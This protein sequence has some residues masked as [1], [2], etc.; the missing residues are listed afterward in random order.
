VQHQQRPELAKQVL[1]RAIILAPD[2]AGYRELST[3]LS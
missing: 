2:N 3:Q 1:A